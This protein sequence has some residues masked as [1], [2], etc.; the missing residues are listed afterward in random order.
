MSKFYEYTLHDKLENREAGV[1]IGYECD[2][3]I[4]YLEFMG[5]VLS[6]EEKNTK[7][8]NILEDW[9]TT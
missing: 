3:L 7:I 8:L 6:D 1:I 2:T 4:G 9:T 5:G